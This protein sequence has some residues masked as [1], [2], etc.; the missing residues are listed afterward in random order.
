MTV[1]IAYASALGSTRE[2]A[3]IWHP[4]WRVHWAR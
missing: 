4:A 1:L 3:N 2:M